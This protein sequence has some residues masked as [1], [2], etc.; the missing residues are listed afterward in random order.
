MA[1]RFCSAQG[2][3]ISTGTSTKTILQVVAPANQALRLTEIG[4]SFQG[5]N[6]TNEPINVELVRQTT[7]GTMSAVTPTKLDDDVAMSVQATAQKT[8]TVE[9][10]TTDVVKSWAVHPQTGL[11]YNF[12][13]MAPVIV[14]GGGRMAIRV[15]TPANSVDCNAYINWEE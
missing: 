8:A 15:N 14:K 9:P 12:N 3:D 2:Q 7:A 5:T 6:N 13:D 4:V 1:A 11:V 10:T